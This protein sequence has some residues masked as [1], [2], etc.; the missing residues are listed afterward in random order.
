MSKTKAHKL[1]GRKPKKKC[2]RKKTRCE[3][4]PVVIHKLNRLAADGAT[5]KELQKSLKSV[6]ANPGRTRAA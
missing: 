1:V 4:C 5:K 2:C 3:R 6:R